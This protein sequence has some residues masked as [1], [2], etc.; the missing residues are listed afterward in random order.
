MFIV[1]EIVLLE[2]YKLVGIRTKL[3]FTTKIVN[4]YQITIHLLYFVWHSTI[5]HF[6]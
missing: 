1:Y 3:R 6:L 5:I 4:R 2:L